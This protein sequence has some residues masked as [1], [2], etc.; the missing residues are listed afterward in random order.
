MSSRSASNHDGRA[1]QTFSKEDRILLRSEFLAATRK[2]RRVSTRYFLVFLRS[3]R[4]GRPRL[5][6]TVSRKIGKAVKRNF[7]KRRIR[8]F[9]RVHK[10]YLPRATDMVIVAKKGIPELPYQIICKDL[11]RFLRSQPCPEAEPSSGER[12]NC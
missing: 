7:L 9:F 4:K 3:N 5:G 12:K 1:D 8:E 6:I 10:A 11:E 2:G